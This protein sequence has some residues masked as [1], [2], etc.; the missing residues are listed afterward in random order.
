MS[1]APA[2]EPD[3]APDPTEQAGHLPAPGGVAAPT[4]PRLGFTAGDVVVVT[5]AGSGIGA[6]TALAAAGQRLVVSAWDR[7]AVGLEVVTNG[8]RAAGGVVDPHVVDVCD[9]RLVQAALLRTRTAHG[10]VRHLVNNAGPAS[11]GD[12]DFDRAVAMCVGSVRSV[13]QAW[14]AD[15]PAGATVVNTASVAGNVVGT[16][17]DWYSAAKAAIAG[18]T[19]HLATHRADVVRANAVAPGMVDTPRLKGF[20]DSDTGQ[21]VLHR[22]PSGRMADPV[23]IAWPILFLLSP[24]SSYVNGTLLVADGG[25]TISQ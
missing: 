8:I 18:Y 10:P 14:L 15:A 19:R 21:A 24:L 17:S 5:G 2:G 23:E 13:T 16:A 12:L 1:A 20:A 25:W 9:T 11:A 6:A 4:R 7:D 3:R 22:V